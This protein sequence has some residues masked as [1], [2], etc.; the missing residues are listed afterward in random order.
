MAGGKFRKF[1]KRNSF[2]RK[3]GY[4]KWAGQSFPLRKPIRSDMLAVKIKSQLALGSDT[5]ATAINSYAFGVEGWTH[6][7]A[8]FAVPT[9]YGSYATKFA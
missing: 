7:V 1:N 9:I 4:Q 3:G 6:V 8:N 2:R 5:N